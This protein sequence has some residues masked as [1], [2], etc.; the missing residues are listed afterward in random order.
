MLR[1]IHFLSE[2]FFINT[3]KEGGRKLTLIFSQNIFNKTELL[4]SSVNFQMWSLSIDFIRNGP[5]P[6]LMYVPMSGQ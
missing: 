4:N 6:D 1:D 5:L 3:S 2:N